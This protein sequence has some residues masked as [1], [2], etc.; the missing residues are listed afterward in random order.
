MKNKFTI[1]IRE[2]ELAKQGKIKYTGRILKFETPIGETIECRETEQIHTF[3]EWKSKGYKVVKGQ[4]AIAK[5][6]IWIPSKKKTEKDKIEI[7][8]WLKNSAWFSESQV[9][10]ILDNN[11]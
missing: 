9:E 11:N 4:K 8:F 3:A 1:L 2:E 7:R 6:P 5:F 10:K